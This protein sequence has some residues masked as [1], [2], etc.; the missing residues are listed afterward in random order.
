MSVSK[1]LIDLPARGEY[2]F[3]MAVAKQLLGSSDVAVHSAIQRL[4][5][6]GDIAMPYR[7]FYVIVPPEYRVLGCLPAEQFI[8]SLMEHRGEAYYAGLLSAAQYHGAA[9]HR[10]QVFQVVTARNKA[11]LEC[12]KV[13]VDFI[14]RKNVKEMPTSTINTPRGMLRLASPE[15][16]AFDLVGYPRHAG[17]LDNVATILAELAEKL[18]PAELAKIAELSPVTWR[19]GWDIY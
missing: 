4:R 13:R 10:P 8:P 19:N 18:D 1:I 12:G 7:G 5:K 14:A 9:H 11:P 17:G 3:T 16:T 6:K 15:T 2:C